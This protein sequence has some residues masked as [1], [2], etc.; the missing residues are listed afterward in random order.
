MSR[1]KRNAGEI[2][3]GSMAD[4]AFLLLIFFLVTTTMSKDK[5]IPMLL[6]PH[7]EEPEPVEIHDRNTLNILVNKENMLLV[8]GDILD[9]SLL[10]EQTKRFLQNDGKLDNLPESS[11]KAV[12]SIETHRGT[13][14]EIYIEIL[15]E[16][17]A[18]YKE[19]RNEYSQG[20]YN[21]NYVEIKKIA[22]DPLHEKRKK[23]K[24]MVKVIRKKFPMKISEAD[25]FEGTPQ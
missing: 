22:D 5:G 7:I 8:E 25:P 3:A 10:K 18:A 1:K 17:K 21:K 14:Y 15:N 13:S 23:H 11:E 4:I 2:N 9:V 16:L 12:V 24:A 19:C 20:L 6:P